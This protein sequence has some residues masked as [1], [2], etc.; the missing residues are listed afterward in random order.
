ML[1][2]S[3]LKHDSVVMHFLKPDPTEWWR[4]AVQNYEKVV[5]GPDVWIKINYESGWHDWCLGSICTA[6]YKFRIE[7][8]HTGLQFVTP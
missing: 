4:A 3:T 8:I 1:K 2:A 5:D 7:W 6:S